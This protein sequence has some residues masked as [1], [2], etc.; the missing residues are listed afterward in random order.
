MEPLTGKTATTSFS[1]RI[2][3]EGRKGATSEQCRGAVPRAAPQA[4]SSQAPPLPLQTPVPGS[5]GCS[6]RR[7]SRPAAPARPGTAPSPLFFLPGE[8]GAGRR[9]CGCRQRAEPGGRMAQA[10]VPET[11]PSPLL[12]IPLLHAQDRPPCAA[13][14]QGFGDRC[15]HGSEIP[16]VGQPL[17]PLPTPT[18]CPKSAGAAEL[19]AACFLAFVSSGTN[20][21]FWVGPT[22][23][24]TKT[25][26]R[27]RWAI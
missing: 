16:A 1:M 27:A 6:D 26:L 3:W 17:G 15:A 18:L 7:R 4:T 19:G 24:S 22:K 10:S 14:A 11:R 9:R 2:S 5:G 23:T 21:S 25:S 8:C 13:P 20:D 12:S